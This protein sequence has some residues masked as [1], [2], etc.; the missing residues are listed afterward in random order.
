MNHK[1]TKQI[2]LDPRNHAIL[3][4]IL[5]KYPYKFYVYGSRVTG[6]SRKYS[7]IDLLCKD[8]MKKGDLFKIIDQ[9]EESNI[10]IKVDILE[11]N[12]CSKRFMQIIEKDL[13]E[14][15]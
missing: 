3:R 7:D 15:T 11:E 6:R 13:I 14:F 12:R 5:S 4:N 2:Q 1:E 8:S 9:I 10:T